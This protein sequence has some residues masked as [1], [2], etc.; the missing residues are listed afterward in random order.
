MADLKVALLVDVKELGLVEML[1]L[2]TV[3]Q[4]VIWKVECL[5]DQ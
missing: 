1:D 2:R 3:G 4:M 5:A